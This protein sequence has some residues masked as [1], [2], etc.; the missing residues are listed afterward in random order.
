LG[1]SSVLPACYAINPPDRISGRILGPFH[2]ASGS[3]HDTPEKEVPL[4]SPSIPPVADL[5]LLLRVVIIRK[6]GDSSNG[7]SF[8]CGLATKSIANDP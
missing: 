4:R 1:G 8:R 2:A 7:C 3:A 6:I 5:E